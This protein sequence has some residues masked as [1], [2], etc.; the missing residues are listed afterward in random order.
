M[1]T[2]RK[3]KKNFCVGRQHGRKGKGHILLTWSCSLGF[4]GQFSLIPL[5]FTANFRFSH[6]LNNK[7]QL[8]FL[9]LSTLKAKC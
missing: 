8:I 9:M 1:A 7:Y 6:V 5:S 2:L 4:S 3:I